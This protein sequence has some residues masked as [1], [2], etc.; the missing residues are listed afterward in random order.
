MSRSYISLLVCSFFL[1]AAAVVVTKPHIRRVAVSSGGSLLHGGSQAVLSDYSSQASKL[2]KGHVASVETRLHA[3]RLAESPLTSI[4]PPD[5]R[6]EACTSAS[7]DMQ[8][9]LPTVTLVIPYLMEEWHRI[10]NFVKSLVKTTNMALIDDVRFVDDGNPED[11]KFVRQIRELHPKVS[12]ISNEKRVGLIRS[13]VIG[14]AGAK[15][16]IL[17]FLEPHCVFGHSWLE[18]LL[19]HMNKSFESTVTMPVL[20]V[21]HGDYLPD[22]P[23]NELYARGAM[24]TGVFNISTMGFL[25][26]GF[27]ASSN[28]TAPFPTPAMPGGIFAMWRSFWESSGT[29]DAEMTEWGGENI[30]MS[31]RVWTC[32][33]RIEIV[34]CSHI[35][36]WFRKS[37]PYVFHGEA[38]RRN[39]KRAALVWLDSYASL[40]MPTDSHYQQLD[41]GDLTSRVALRR[42]L[43]CKPFQWYINHVDPK[44]LNRTHA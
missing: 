19:K 24:E 1:C 33:G 10:S 3:H 30:E 32:G 5:Y 21:I 20:D 25:W 29:Y 23:A 41:A 12:V 8:E 31:V 35:F 37:R 34:P 6:A 17:I 7:Q 44:I 22:T 13:K 16:P 40:A 36:H 26:D 14:A 18:P 11:H 42:Q 4:D 2:Q 38:F 43:G 28:E 39:S 9:G 27:I 15:S